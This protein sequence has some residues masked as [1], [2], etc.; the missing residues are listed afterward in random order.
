MERR[1]LLAA[2]VAGLAGLGAGS[3][4]AQEKKEPREG[5]AA[6]AGGPAG[7]IGRGVSVAGVVGARQGRSS[8]SVGV[9]RSW[10]TS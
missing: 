1:E 6:A 3:A 9:S 7:A 8:A 4:F 2:G 10:P 5:H